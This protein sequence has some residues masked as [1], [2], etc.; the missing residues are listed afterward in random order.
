MG[1]IKP[2]LIEIGVFVLVIF[3]LSM[4]ARSRNRLWNDEIGLWIDCAGKSPNKARP[5]VNLGL[6]YFNAGAYDKSQGYGKEGDRDRP[7]IRLCVLY[8]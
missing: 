6:A 4:G 1:K 5:Y 8:P 7:E 2:H 3:A